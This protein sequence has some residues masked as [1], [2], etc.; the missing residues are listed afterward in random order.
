[1]SSLCLWEDLLFYDVRVRIVDF[2]DPLSHMMARM[3]SKGMQALAKRPKTIPVIEC[4]FRY[5]SVAQLRCLKTTFDPKSSAIQAFWAIQAS[6]VTALDWLF[7]EK[8]FVPTS[9][10]LIEAAYYGQQESMAWLLANGCVLDSHALDRAA[11]MDHTALFFWMID[12]GCPVGDDI[13]TWAARGG[14]LNILKYFY[15]QKPSTFDTRVIFRGAVLSARLHVLGW[16]LRGG[17]VMKSHH[18]EWAI[19]ECKSVDVLEWFHAHQCP[20]RQPLQNLFL[21]PSDPKVRWLREK[22]YEVLD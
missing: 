2:L 4:Y 6:N 22:G 7:K 5:G 10:H 11:E 12:Q 21:D 18:F 19:T 9:R 20:L 8:E 3:V 13:L 16:L 14:S 17:Y 1:M 15:K